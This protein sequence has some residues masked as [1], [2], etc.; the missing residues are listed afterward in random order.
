MSGHT[1]FMQR[2][3]PKHVWLSALAMLMLTFVAVV[4]DRTGTL[5][6]VRIVLHNLLSPGR[7]IILAV[8]PA[9][10]G[11]PGSSHGSRS[12]AV[13]ELTDVTDLQN[14]LLENEL[15]RRQLL[16]ENARLHNELRSSREQ[17]AAG[18][19]DIVPLVNFVAVKA[20]ILSHTG[21]S[22]NVRGLIVDA[23][24]AS[25]L[26]PSD[27]L[28]DGSGI[29]LDQGKQQ[30]IAAGQR[31]VNGMTVVGRITETS[32]WV[33][34]VQPVSHEE[35]SAAVQLVRNSPQGAAFGAEG[36]L[37]GIGNGLCRVSGVA[38]TEAVSVGDEVFSADINGINGPRLYYGKVV[39][40][41]FSA[42]GEW[43]VQVKPA[44]DHRSLDQVA[45]VQPTVNRS[46]SRIS[47]EHTL[48]RSAGVR[49]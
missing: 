6:P 46:R 12:R 26:K 37:V 11:S 42:G 10:P 13:S 35:F 43:D 49:R 18:I 41:E 16:I 38:Y 8:A 29:L 4:A 45:V 40:A 24:R 19:F 30:G 21:L 47:S 36:L 17:S 23:G 31:V 28:V 2:T 15:Q 33:A 25:Q 27:L 32:Q 39:R 20:N 5:T 3:S 9:D 14:A 44:V 7:L 48:S 34:L 1:Q 22:G